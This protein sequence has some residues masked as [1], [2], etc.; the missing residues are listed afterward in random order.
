MHKSNSTYLTDLD[1]ARGHHV[2]GLLRVGIHKYSLEAEKQ[3]QSI[4]TALGGVS[5]SFKRQIEP[6]QKFEI[7]TRVLSWD[8]KWLYLVSHFVKPGTRLAKEFSDQPWRT[9]PNDS[10]CSK[11]PQSGEKTPGSHSSSSETGLYATCISKYVF[12]QGRKTISPVSMIEES[13]LL[14]HSF[15]APKETAAVPKTDA[16]AQLTPRMAGKVQQTANSAEE[17]ARLTEIERRRQKGMSVAL[18]FAALDEAHALFRD[19][20]DVAFAQY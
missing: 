13:G 3:K 2:Y 5:C 16:D 11:Q 15:D 8:E 6:Y 1:M 20:D 12:K 19:L 10:K 4:G 14:P 18:H 9:Y 7:W 17:A